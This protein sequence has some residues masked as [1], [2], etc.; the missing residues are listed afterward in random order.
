MKV[1]ESVRSELQQHLTEQ[2]GTREILQSFYAPEFGTY[3]SKVHHAIGAPFI[4]LNSA[5]DIFS[6]MSNI[7]EL[8]LSHT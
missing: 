5:W 3:A 8:E 4:A 1:P 2:V 6:A 7:M